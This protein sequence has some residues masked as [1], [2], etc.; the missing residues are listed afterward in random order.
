MSAFHRWSGCFNS[1][2][3]SFGMSSRGGGPP[4]WSDDRRDLGLDA[5]SASVVR[6]VRQDAEEQDNPDGGHRPSR[7][8][9]HGAAGFGGGG[10]GIVSAIFVSVLAFAY[11]RILSNRRRE[12]E[13]QESFAAVAGRF[14]KSNRVPRTG[15]GCWDT[16]RS[17]AA[18]SSRRAY[19]VRLCVHQ[20]RL[21]GVW[22]E[23]QALHQ[24]HPGSDDLFYRG[25]AAIRK[26]SVRQ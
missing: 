26:D 1:T 24:L 6:E 7:I 21:L 17:L 18:G 20:G 25:K 19:C 2:S 3:S 23:H 11:Y 8:R 9:L 15:L 12:T 14:K 4:L 13:N 22:K 5:G 10:F 16:A